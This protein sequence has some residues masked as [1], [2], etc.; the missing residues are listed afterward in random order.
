[1]LS[2]WPSSTRRFNHIWLYISYKR[3]EKENIKILQYQRNMMIFL[4]KKK[5]KGILDSFFFN[6]KIAKW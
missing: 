5:K 2:H 1:M 4:A 3:K 6:I